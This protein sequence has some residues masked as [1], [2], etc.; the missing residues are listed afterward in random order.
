MC[1]LSPIKGQPAEQS[2][3]AT[4]WSARQPTIRTATTIRS[5]EQPSK[6]T[7]TTK[8]STKQSTT[9]TKWSTTTAE[10]TTTELPT[11]TKP[12]LAIE[13]TMD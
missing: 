4:E 13:W 2:T 9:A 10:W 7:T 5:T 11:A 6:R 1:F 3:T 12:E 8:Q